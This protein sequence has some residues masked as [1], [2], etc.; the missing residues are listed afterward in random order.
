MFSKRH[1]WRN[2]HS[3]GSKKAVNFSDHSEKSESDIVDDVIDDVF[4]PLGE[5]THNGQFE[6]G[7]HW[8]SFSD[9]QITS[10][11][12]TLTKLRNENNQS[13]STTN[14]SNPHSK[15]H[16]RGY[17]QKTKHMDHKTYNMYQNTA[18]T[19][20][21]TE[22]VEDTDELGNF[23]TGTTCEMVRLLTAGLSIFNKLYK[24]EFYFISWS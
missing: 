6:A 9:S 13:T 10:F 1:K 16:Q 18:T 12:E 19:A 17:V 7:T 23:L 20:A 4:E 14:S 11:S 2:F 22:V 8:G 15:I 5:T 3:S 21:V 24:I